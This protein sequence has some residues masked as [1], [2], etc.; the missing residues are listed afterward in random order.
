MLYESN[1]IRIY[2]IPNTFRKNIN[3]FFYTFIRH[4]DLTDIFARGQMKV[5]YDGEETFLLI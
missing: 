2:H 1:Y 3:I 5:R 4:V